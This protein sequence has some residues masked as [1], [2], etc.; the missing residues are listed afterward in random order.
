[1]PRNILL[2]MTDQQRAEYVGYAPG[3]VVDTPNIDR[4]ARE[5]AY[6]T[7]CNTTNPI[8]TPARTSLI[9]GRYSRQIGTLTM[10]G[11]LFPQIPT[12]MQA[13]QQ[14]GY[15]TY[16]IGKYHFSQ[17]YPWS[18][19][20]G[21]GMDPVAEEQAEQSYGFDFVWETAGKQQ[22]VSNY[23][24]YCDYLQKKGMLEPVRDFFQQCGGPN[25]DVPHHNYDKALPWP[26]DEEDYIDVVTGRV[27]REQLRQHPADQPFYMMVSF[28]G[29][30]KP[31]DAPQRYLDMFP[32]EREDDFLLPEG[33]EIAEADKEALWRQRRSAK[34]MIRLI[35]DQIGEILAL[36]EERRMLEDT[37]ILFTSDHGDMLGDHCLLQKGVPWRQAVNVPLAIRLPGAQPAGENGSPVELSDLAATILDYAGLDAQ[38]ALGRSWPAYNDIIPCRSLL[39]ILRGE[40]V[41]IRD[42]C[43]AESDFTEE[44][45]QGVPI[46]A[47]P[48]WRGAGGRRSN[49]WQAI[50]TED[51]KYIKYLGYAL[52]ETPYEE[53]YDLKADPLE[54]ASRIDD[55][56]YQTQIAQARARL[57]YVTDH[58][59]AAQKTWHT[60]SARARMK[61]R[62]DGR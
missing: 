20:R 5:G 23:C 50:I 33:Q 48:Y 24:F 45:I 32:P 51:S 11:D 41:R 62:G 12:F 26:F 7:C 56:A 46:T 21:C 54:T 27:A 52:G 14:H 61:E 9:T 15:K 1:M 31:Y 18:T 17:T 57:A 55:P 10:S 59:P 22:T 13:L 47:T 53:F 44:R 36:L 30:H 19:P 25:G 49:A 28:C 3:S 6:F 39:P 8:C 43:Y 37:L 58:H 40:A 34:A 2:L 16:G 38:Q 42:F 60:A 29:P 35:D 4:I